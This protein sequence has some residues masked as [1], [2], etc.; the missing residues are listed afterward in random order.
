MYQFLKNLDR[1]WVFLLMGLAV[2]LPILLG[3]RFPEEPSPMVRQVFDVIQ[4]AEQGSTVL[5]AWDYDP[6]SQGELQP[7]ASAFT[8]HCAERHHKMIFVTLWPQ[9]GPMIERSIRILKEEYP[10]YKYGVDYVNLGYRPGLEGVIKV[11]V[12]D[13]KELFTSDAYGTSL[14]ELPLT[15]GMK[16][17]QN[18]DLLVNVSAG[19]PGTKQWVQYAATPYNITMVAGATGV[20]APALYPYI[21]DQMKGVLG[22]IKAAAEYEQTL[23]EAYPKFKDNPNAKEGLRRMGPQ[24]IAHGLMIVLIV[25]GN[26]IF[27]IGRSRGTDR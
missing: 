1:R 18:V 2:L 4:N 22:A 21:P 6:G 17:I 13:M 15:K 23:I 10:D 8:R 16:N 3:L 24:L 12:S 27:F 19:D 25:V 7:M 26:V 9:G 20:Q 14:D 5:M 11:A